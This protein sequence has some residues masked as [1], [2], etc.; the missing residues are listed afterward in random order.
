MDGPSD[1]QAAVPWLRG[2][3]AAC[4][5]VAGVGSIWT[6]LT[7]VPSPD[8]IEPMLTVFRV[9]GVLFGILCVTLATFG[10]VAGRQVAARR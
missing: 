3:R 4:I 9:L 6:S 1:S 7:L 8:A 2:W 5:G 10:I